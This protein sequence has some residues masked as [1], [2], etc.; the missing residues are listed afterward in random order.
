MIRHIAGWT[1]LLTALRCKG[2]P[3]KIDLTDNAL[4]HDHKAI[5]SRVFIFGVWT[6][7]MRKNRYRIKVPR[8]FIGG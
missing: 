7:F 4:I 3:M 8:E 1:G 6:P 5:W 2:D